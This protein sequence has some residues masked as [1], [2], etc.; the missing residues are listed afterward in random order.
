LVSNKRLGA[1]TTLL[2]LFV[3]VVIL[4]SMILISEMRYPL[5]A[6]KSS[7]A[8]SPTG[9]SSSHKPDSSGNGTSGTSSTS[10]GSTP[11]DPTHCD[12][13]GYPSCYSIGYTDGQNS[14]GKSCPSGHSASFC[15][16]WE[17][18][19][20]SAG[21]SLSGAGTSSGTESGGIAPNHGESKSSVKQSS[22]VDLN[23]FGQSRTNVSVSNS[24]QSIVN[25]K[26]N[27]GNTVGVNSNLLSLPSGHKLKGHNAT[28]EIKCP[29]QS[30]RSIYF[31]S[32]CYKQFRESVKQQ[33][34]YW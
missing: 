11:A 21:N 4:S 3:A 31:E 24:P 27:I 19:S 8:S 25:S 1:H 10:S 13:T 2:I 7:H 22:K 17:A 16:G 5:F 26:S 30:N 14:P 6:K 12:L 29:H 34:Q 20:L 15:A 32:C 28:S 33:I 23:Q 18:G 9:A